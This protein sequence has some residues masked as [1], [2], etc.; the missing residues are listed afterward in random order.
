MLLFQII[1]KDNDFPFYK[2]F[3]YYY[4]S[5]SLSLSPHHARDN[6]QSLTVENH[7]RE[8]API[9]GSGAILKSHYNSC[10]VYSLQG[11][12]FQTSVYE[13]TNML[14]EKISQVTTQVERNLLFINF[15]DECDLPILLTNPPK[16]NNM[17][18]PVTRS[19]PEDANIVRF[20]VE[21][22][23]FTDASSIE[24]FTTQVDQVRGR[25]KREGE[26]R[27]QRID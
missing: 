18:I 8:N 10:L 5:P 27:E 25:W 15:L 11:H 2:F 4:I 9:F 3:C 12:E 21:K 17:E 24:G 7:G 14:R 23:L 22:L 16:I 13:I 20:R 6:P 1:I 26:E 19:F